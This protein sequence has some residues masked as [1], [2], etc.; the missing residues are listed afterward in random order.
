MARLR[1]NGLRTTLGASL[2]NSATS[3]TFAAALTHSNGTA[4]PTLAGSDYIPLTILDASGRESEIVYLTAYTSGATTGT[5]ARGKEGTTGV[6][7]SSGDVIGCATLA[8]DVT[9][10]GIIACTAYN[11]GTLAAYTTTATTDGD[12][13]ATNL[14]VTFTAPTSGKVL[15]RLSGLTGINSTTYQLMWGLRESSTSLA[16]SQVNGFVDANKNVFLSAPMVIT[17][18]TPGSSHT[19]KWSW[20]TTGASSTGRLYAGGIAGAA[21]ME[22]SA[23]P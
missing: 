10:V 8:A 15:V 23:L 1:Y 2:T 4:V 22:V 12:V 13:D 11:P 17:G 16:A 9:D 14:A 7:H 6:A 18:L 5:I 21:V 3:V 20:Y 19:Y